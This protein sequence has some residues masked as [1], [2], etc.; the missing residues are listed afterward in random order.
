MLIDTLLLRIAFGPSDWNNKAVAIVRLDEGAGP[1]DGN[2]VFSG[3]S[4][5]S[6][7]ETAKNGSTQ[8]RSLRPWTALASPPIKT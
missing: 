4:S 7:P 3:A 2:G 5:R 6:A 1:A 8:T